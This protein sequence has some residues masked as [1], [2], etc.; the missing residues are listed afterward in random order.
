M[1]TKEQRIKQF[2]RFKAQFLLHGTEAKFSDDGVTYILRKIVFKGKGKE[3]E[4]ERW[5]LRS[6]RGSYTKSWDTKSWEVNHREV[7]FDYLE[8][9]YVDGGGNA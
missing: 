7:M 8:K 3:K 2:N 5:E 6:Y 9:V 4:K 1:S